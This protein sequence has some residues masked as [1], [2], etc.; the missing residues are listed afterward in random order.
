MT[1]GKLNLSYEPL[2]DS[3]YALPLLH[4][5]NIFPKEQIHFV[6]GDRLLFDPIP[7]LKRLE[8]F[9]RVEHKITKDLIYFDEEK[10][11]LCMIKNGIKSCLPKKKGHLH[12]VVKQDVTEKLKEFFKP[13]NKLFYEMANRTFEW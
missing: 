13:F 4:W 7:E 5:Q 11:F 10:R 12:P 2:I 9:L 8:T 3:L 1:N 6:D